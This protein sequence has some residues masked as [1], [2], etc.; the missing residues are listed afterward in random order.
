M[1]VIFKNNESVLFSAN[2]TVQYALYSKQITN[3]STI[4]DYDLIYQEKHSDLFYPF[5]SEYYSKVICSVYESG[6]E[7]KFLIFSY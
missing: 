5:Y 7:P 6:K 2:Q 3:K 1:D 4:N